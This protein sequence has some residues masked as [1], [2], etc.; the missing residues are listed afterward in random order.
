[1]LGTPTHSVL[2]PLLL[3]GSMGSSCCRCAVDHA[4]MQCAVTLRSLSLPVA[5]CITGS[6]ANMVNVA[7]GCAAVD[8]EKVLGILCRCTFARGVPAELYVTHGRIN[9]VA[10]SHV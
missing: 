2:D 10:R 1:M 7:P 9:A 3:L 5:I 4:N 8:L 6:H